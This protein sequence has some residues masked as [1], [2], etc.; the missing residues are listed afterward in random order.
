MGIL[1]SSS[2]CS[3]SHIR[4]CKIFHISLLLHSSFVLR[5]CDL[6]SDNLELRCTSGPPTPCTYF[7]SPKSHRC[8]LQRIRRN[9]IAQRALLVQRYFRS[10]C[11]N[12]PSRP[13]PCQTAD[14]LPLLSHELQSREHRCAA[15]LLFVR[16]A[17]RS[18]PNA[19][20]RYLSARDG[21]RYIKGEGRRRAD[22]LTIFEPRCDA[23][24]R[25]SR[26]QG[27]CFATK[28]Q[29]QSRGK[30]FWHLLPFY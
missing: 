5:T 13:A 3:T 6:R 18:L 28:S 26:S 29:S 1:L 4:L 24:P 23:R 19:T 14:I 15:V 10:L 7:S 16:K 27:K 22:L 21:V 9:Q 20:F 2:S 12:T 11:Q 8:S 17:V 30:R 25:P